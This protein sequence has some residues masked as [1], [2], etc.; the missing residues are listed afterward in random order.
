M[1]ENYFREKY[2]I[3]TMTEDSYRMMEESRETKNR[4]KIIEDT[5]SYRMM[6]MNKYWNKF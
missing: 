3:F 2:G 5:P 4:S 6:E 1:H